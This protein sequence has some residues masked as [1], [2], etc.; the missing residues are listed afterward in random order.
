MMEIA[1]LVISG[2]SLLNDLWGR[3]KDLSTWAESDL[4]VNRDYLPLALAKGIIQGGEGDFAWASEANVPTLEL[5][6]THCV[7]IA[8]NEDKKTKY[9]ITRGRSG[10][11]AI[12]M[13]RVDLKP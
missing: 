6:G 8:Y 5:R 1:G 10:D 4:L 3:Y 7:V 11:R 9:R 13:K 2:V 12:L